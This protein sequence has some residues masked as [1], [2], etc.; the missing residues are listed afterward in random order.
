[1]DYD[2]LLLV[3]QLRFY[4]VRRIVRLISDNPAYDPVDNI[5]PEDLQVFG[6]AIW[7]PRKL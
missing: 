6:R 5:N 2:G 3:K 7:L 4:P 1:V